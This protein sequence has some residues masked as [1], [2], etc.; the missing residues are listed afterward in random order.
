MPFVAAFP[1]PRFERDKLHTCISNVKD[2]L[3]AEWD[4]LT[5]TSLSFEKGKPDRKA[6]TQSHW[7]KEPLVLHDRGIAEGGLLGCR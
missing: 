4:A 6:G 2:I 5:R 7:S 3:M 1:R